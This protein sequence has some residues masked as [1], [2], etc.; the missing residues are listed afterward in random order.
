M[1]CILWTLKSVP[2]EN[3]LVETPYKKSALV[4]LGK[5]QQTNKQKTTHL[6]GFSNCLSFTISQSLLKQMSIELVMP[7]NHLVLCHFFFSCLLS[8]P[9]S[10]S[11]LMN[12]L[13]ASGGY[14]IG[15]SALVSVPPIN[16]QDWFPLGLTGLISLQSNG[17]SRVFSNTTVQKHHLWYHSIIDVDRITWTLIFLLIIHVSTHL[18]TS[19]Y[20]CVMEHIFILTLLFL[21]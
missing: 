17:L 16:I 5:K 20:F 9:A 8:F 1:L 11:F 15:A 6:F 13:Y 21:F 19:S 2:Q 12:Q 3:K 7:S 4:T 18:F 14:S 10:G